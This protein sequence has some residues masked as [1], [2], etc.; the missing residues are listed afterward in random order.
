M[1]T[2][3]SYLS[4]LFVITLLVPACGSS[5]GGGTAAD[6]LG[7]AAECAREADCATFNTADG[8][9]IQLQCLTD[10]KGG[11]CGIEGCASTA[12]CPTGAICVHH[13][14]NKNYCFRYCGD[15]SECNRNRT[16]DN[17]ANCSANFDWAKPSDDDGS[18]ACI[19]PSG[20]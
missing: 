18:K 14:D 10:F 11:Y 2:A 20:T 9:Q 4:T 6:R 1:K 19:P 5:D 15:K 3:F 16:P 8:G 12:D 17:E 7:V 13:S